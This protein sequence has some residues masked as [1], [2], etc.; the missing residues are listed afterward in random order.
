MIVSLWPLR[1]AEPPLYTAKAADIIKDKVTGKEYIRDKIILWHGEKAKPPI[2]IEKS[3]PDR[4]EFIY[5]KGVT[6]LGTEN[7]LKEIWVDRML[8]G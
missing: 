7:Y 4:W 5:L 1:G 6:P 2:P 8:R 3:E